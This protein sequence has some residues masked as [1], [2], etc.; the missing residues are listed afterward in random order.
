M[1]DP[2]PPGSHDLIVILSM[3]PESRDCRSAASVDSSLKQTVRYGLIKKSNN[4]TLIYS[5]VT[6]SFSIYGFTIGEKFDFD[7]N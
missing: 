2:P 1:S 6:V 3:V 4:I 5:F 7:K